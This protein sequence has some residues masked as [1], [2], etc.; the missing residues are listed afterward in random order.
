MG[1]DLIFHDQ[2]RGG[3]VISDKTMIDHIRKSVGLGN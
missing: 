1:I 2:N 3:G